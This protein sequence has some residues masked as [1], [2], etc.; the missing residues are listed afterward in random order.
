V[1][2]KNRIFK[3]SPGT[4]SEKISD[5]KAGLATALGAKNTPNFAQ[6]DGVL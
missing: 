4:F 6:D 2:R 5:G 1:A 3:D